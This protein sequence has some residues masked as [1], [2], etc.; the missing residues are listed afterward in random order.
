MPDTEQPELPNLP[1]KRRG[2]RPLALDAVRVHTVSVRLNSAELAD[3]DSA[4]AFVK[5]A[6]GQYLRA[7]SR[8]VLPPTIPQINRDAWLNLAR[9]A[10][11]LNQYQAQINAG[12]VI[13]Q[14]SEVIEE[15]RDLVQKLRFELL[16]IRE[17]EA[18]D[19][20]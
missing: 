5:M 6:R 17:S 1:R 3:L 4:R 18:E 8:G 19:E 16:G 13:G 2:P 15:L 11:N 20:S 14:P 10:G 12:T 9:V 7:A